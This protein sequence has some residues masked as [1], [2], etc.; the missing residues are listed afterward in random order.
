MDAMHLRV[1]TIL[2][3]IL[4]FGAGLGVSRGMMNGVGAVFSGDQPL[5]AGATAAQRGAAVIK[6]HLV[7]VQLL[8][9]AGKSCGLQVGDEITEIDEEAVAGRTVAD[10][11]GDIDGYF[12]STVV[13]VVK[14][15]GESAPLTLTVVRH[16]AHPSGTTVSPIGA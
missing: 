1:R 4:M 8:G 2:L 16:Y 13:L 14:R 11:L 15:K 5:P 3:A 9:E 6:N 12:D 10:A 7:V